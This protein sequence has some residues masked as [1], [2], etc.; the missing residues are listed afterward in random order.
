MRR[1]ESYN[2]G[3]ERHV[4]GLRTVQK[5]RSFLCIFTVEALVVARDSSG[6]CVLAGRWGQG[7]ILTSCGCSTNVRI[8]CSVSTQSGTGH[9]PGSRCPP[10]TLL[11]LPCVTALV[12]APADWSLGFL[13]LGRDSLWNFV[14]FFVSWNTGV[15]PLSLEHHLLFL[16]QKFLQICSFLTGLFPVFCCCCGSW[17]I[18]VGPSNR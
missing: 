18:L 9:W 11:I 7:G 13:G 4:Q 16:P 6:L 15:Q 2:P 5:A 12:S 14:C 17:V 8:S 1:W 10:N 3:S